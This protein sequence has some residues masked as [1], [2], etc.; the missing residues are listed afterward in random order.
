[1]AAD[2]PAASPTPRIDVPRADAGPGPSLPLVDIS[3]FRDP[4]RREAFLA[5]LRHAAHDVGFFYVTGHGVPGDVT[6]A[7]LDA[8]REFF[9]LPMEQRLEI[10]NLKSPQFRGYS[11]VGTEHTAGAA[12]QRDQ[13]D[14]GHE[15]PALADVPADKP[16]LRLELLEVATQG[17][18]RATRH[19]VVSPA[20]GE[21]F[22]VPVFLGPRLDAVVQPLQLPAELAREARGV[23]DDPDNPLLAQYGEKSL[24]GWLRS[25]PAV[26]QR[27]YA[28]VLAAGSDHAGREG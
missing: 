22:S 12:D 28:D 13:I 5:D 26:A 27:W 19:R 18:L 20:G 24:I 9:A 6:D 11:Q 8:A 16:Y 15:H 23:E 7:V 1:M 25:H 10:E 17:Y 21:R 14:V 2:R 3:G 4:G